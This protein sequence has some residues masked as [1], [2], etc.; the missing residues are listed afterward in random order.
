[1]KF[2]HFIKTHKKEITD[3]WVKFAKDNIECVGKLD[4]EE[5]RDHIKQMLDRVVESMESSETDAQQEE[6]SKGNM[7]M[8]SGESEAAN[9]HGEQRADKGFNLI[10]LCSEFRALRAS[11][12][13]LWEANSKAGKLETDFQ[14][15]IRFNEAIDELLI[16]SVERFQNKVDDSKNWFMGI[17][18]HDLRNPLAA[19]SGVQSILKMSKNLSEKEKS[20]LGRAGSSVKRMAELIDNLLELTNLRLGNGMN[21]NKSQVD[22]STQST[23]IVQ[24][25]QI[26][27]PEAELIIESPGPVQ[28]E[29]DVLRLDQLMTNLITNALR[30]GKPGGPVTVS[31]LAKGNDAFFKIH[32]E[33]PLIPK[34]IKEMISTGNFTKTNGD[35]TKR[36]SYGLGLYIIKQIVD[37]H[38]GQI[39]VSSTEEKGTNFEITLPRKS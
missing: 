39:K 16:I 1:M 9:Q 33:G 29:W 4:L 27:Y 6:K 35:P 7:N 19:I 30:H 12:L 21:I 20:L 14:D 2:A 37:G 23:K 10:E 22:L 26:A 28:G 31:I 24:E 32:N 38:N 36:D 25:L 13:R 3:E 8:L 5:V 11:V 15:M 34:S 17:L 18:G